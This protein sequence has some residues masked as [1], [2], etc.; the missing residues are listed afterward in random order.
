MGTSSKLVFDPHAP[1]RPRVLLADAHPSSKGRLLVGL[2]SEGYDVVVAEDWAQLAFAVDAVAR[3][4]GPAPD[5]IVLD[6]DLGHGAALATMKRACDAIA[7][8]PLLLLVS[9]LQRPRLGL[10][11]WAIVER[12]VDP[13]VVRSSM[14][15]LFEGRRL[16]TEGVTMS[17]TGGAR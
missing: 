9:D 14:Q 11:P 17:K 12:P 8:V 16:D 4:L 7:R 10:I 15:F 3:R 5:A 6:A 2:A 1:R 13:L